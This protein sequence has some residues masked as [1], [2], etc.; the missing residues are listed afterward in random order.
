MSAGMGGLYRCHLETEWKEQVP[1]LPSRS[2]V[3]LWL[4]YWQILTVSKLA[5]QQCGLP[6][7]SVLCKGGFGAERQWLNYWHNHAGGN[8]VMCTLLVS[9]ALLSALT[10]FLWTLRI[11][12][13]I[14]YLYPCSGFS[15]CLYGRDC[16]RFSIRVPS[17]F[18][19][20][21]PNS[22]YYVIRSWGLQYDH[23]G[24]A[25]MYGISVSIRRYMT[26]CLLFICSL[27]FENTKRQ[28]SANQEACS[29]L[30]THPLAP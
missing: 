29:Y 26:T 23:E 19:C 13:Q 30:T 4:S 11:T 27:S 8:S 12:F 6:S 9:S 28:L 22:Q 25:P 15:L 20:W 7:P 2:V 5:T 3:P 10:S 1:S 17:K 18:T 16:N 21:N 24:R 14:K